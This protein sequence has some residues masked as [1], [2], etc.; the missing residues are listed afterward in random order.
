M[1]LSDDDLKKRMTN[2]M[3]L[4]N[5]PKGNISSARENAMSLFIKPSLSKVEEKKDSSVP[6]PA[7]TPANSPFEP[8]KT[9]EIPVKESAI[10]IGTDELIEDA[11][12]RIN[13]AAAHNN[14][15]A[16]M[17]T[18][19]GRVKNGIEDIDVRKLPGVIT[20]MSRVVSE[21][22]KTKLEH[23]K[24]NKGTEVFHHFYMP[25]QKKIESYEVIEVSG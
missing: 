23:E 13:L 7:L 6:V 5:K 16:V 4:L 24:I 25:E 17:N 22:Q 21:I 18:A 1:I 11:D 9:Q 15:I 20:A 19:I 8:A 14:A 10:E 3:N 2:P 12:A